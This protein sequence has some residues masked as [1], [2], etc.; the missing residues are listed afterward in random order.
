MGGGISEA[1][2]A[3]RVVV[4]LTSDAGISQEAGQTPNYELA[5]EVEHSGRDRNFRQ[6]AIIRLAIANVTVG[7]S[8]AVFPKGKAN[9]DG[10]RPCPIL[11]LP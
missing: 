7:L 9:G 2:H 3:G 6:H 8:L 5:M 1:E 11:P 4:D 10:M